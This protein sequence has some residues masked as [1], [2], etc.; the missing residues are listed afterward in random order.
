MAQDLETEHLATLKERSVTRDGMALSALPRR[1]QGR[2]QGAGA[3][4]RRGRWPR[5][6]SLCRG[7]W[8][9]G[10]GSG[11]SKRGNLV[12]MNVNERQR[13]LARPLPVLPASEADSHLRYFPELSF[14]SII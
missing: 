1:S 10:D 13:Q 12:L 9:G 5:G 11:E 2:G 7:G 4:C 14:L 6:T 3:G 8:F